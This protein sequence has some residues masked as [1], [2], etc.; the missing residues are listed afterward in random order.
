MSI[1]INI[2]FQV[3]SGKII[4]ADDLSHMLPVPASFAVD[5]VANFY[6]K[7]NIFNPYVGNTVL[8]GKYVDE[9]KTTIEFERNFD[10]LPDNSENNNELGEIS[11]DSRFMTIVDYDT[12]R[13]LLDV[14]DEEFS[15]ILEKSDYDIKVFDVENGNYTGTLKES[16]CKYYASIKRAVE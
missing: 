9:A 15:E 13:A 10:Y 16:C 3:T 14:S 12:L 1:E 8:V 5:E 11:I 7:L 2:N 6:A 4:V